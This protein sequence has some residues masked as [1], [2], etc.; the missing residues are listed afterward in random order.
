MSDKFYITT[1]I[2][3][4]NGNPH[5][6]HSYT[7]IM[8]D[9]IARYKR[10]KGF[11][12]FFLTGTDEH[13]LKIQRSAEKEGLSPQE[14]ADK[15]VEPFK[16]L[17]KIL[18]ITNDDFIRTTE[19]RHIKTVQILFQKL[20]E[21][22]DIYKGTYK[23]WYCVPCETF[24][25]NSQLEE[26]KLCPEC[27]RPVEEVSEES[28]FF[29]LSKYAPIIKKKIEENP[30][31]CQPE[32]KR[33][34]ILN[35]LSGE[36]KDLSISRTTF[37]WGIP[38]PFDD[39][40]VIYVWFDALINYL[41]A[42]DYFGEN[43]SRKDYWPA[44]IH[45]IGKEIAWFHSVIWPCMLYAL[46][47]PLPERI[48]SHGWLTIEGEKMSKS[49][50]NVIDPFTIS[51]KFGTDALR[52]YL[53]SQINFGNDGDYSEKRLIEKYNADL[54]N[55]L[56]NLLNRTVS[57]IKKYFKDG[58]ERVE[59][60]DN[61]CRE[62]I[63]LAQNLDR[64][65]DE[66]YENLE[67]HNISKEIIKV[68]DAANLLIVKKEPWTLYKKGDINLL[69]E[70]MNTLMISLKEI[71]LALYPLVPQ[72]AQSMWSV[73]GLDNEIEKETYEKLTAV[74][75]NIEKFPI[76]KKKIVFPRLEEK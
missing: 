55:C 25:S 9:I 61:D 70:V 59:I 65:V 72:K 58:L 12:V 2:Y 10:L 39:K 40:H 68:G 51:E 41:S 44:D 50:G 49:L 27:K 24:W 74:F 34:E 32:W 3:Y 46:D 42:I 62:L 28:Y 26:G 29:K 17:T 11:N 57:M 6:G 76:P 63:E 45:L 30:N 7:S 5:I 36:I 56:G 1:P 69:K 22:G 48:F 67:L 4:I 33:N 71:T 13:G 35:R 52:Y 37:K 60:R 16:K 23:G 31:L 15:M 14:F 73:L 20:Y 54:A 47:I 18:N 53:S 66:K 8:A 19:E 64:K 75:D 38:V 43:S 21:K